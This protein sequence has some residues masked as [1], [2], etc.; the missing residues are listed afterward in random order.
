MKKQIMKFARTN[1]TLYPI[2]RWMRDRA[3]YVRDRRRG[4]FSQHG[5]D[6]VVADYFA[7]KAGGFYVDIGASHPSL[8]SNTALLYFEYGWRGVTVEPLPGLAGLHRRWR[9]EDRLAEVAIGLVPGRLIFHELFPSVLSTLDW[10]V[11]ET[12][13]AEGRAERIKEHDIDVIT[14][15]GLFDSMGRSAVDF[16]SIDLEGLDAAVVQSCRFERVR[17]QLICVEF[18]DWAGRAAVLGHLSTCGY[19]FFAETEC[20]LLMERVR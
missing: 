2:V 9:P 6:L 12:A 8:L 15:D 14:L 19:E 7:G 20:N 16:L 4:T 13:I 10:G 17:P 18:A 1:E 3:L 5:E 11:A